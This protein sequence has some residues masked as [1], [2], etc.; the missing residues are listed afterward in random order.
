M[1]RTQIQIT[2]AQATALK[3]LAAQRGLSVAALIRLSVDRFLQ[4]ETKDEA[5]QQ[6]IRRRAILEPNLFHSGLADL[7]RNH[8]KYLVEAYSNGRYHALDEQSFAIRQES[9]ERQTD[10]RQGGL[11]K[12]V[13]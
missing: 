8:D 7:G 11:V 9:T 5:D 12:V 3:K 10:E 2:K 1:V 4:T 6:E 13:V